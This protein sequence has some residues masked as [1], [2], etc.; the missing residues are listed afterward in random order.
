M[1]AMKKSAFSEDSLQISN[2]ITSEE[3]AKRPEK[4]AS[5][6]NL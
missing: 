5:L 3:E 4:A 2:S 1:I 6:M